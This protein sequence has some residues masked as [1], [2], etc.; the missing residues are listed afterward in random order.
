MLRAQNLASAATYR[1]CQALE[2]APTC[3][4]LL[5]T[6][7]DLDGREPSASSVQVSASDREDPG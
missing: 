1:Y 6:D 4:L 5:F 7:V 3:D 2:A